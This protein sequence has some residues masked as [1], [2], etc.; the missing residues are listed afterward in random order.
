MRIFQSEQVIKLRNVIVFEPKNELA[1]NSLD[2]KQLDY[3]V[4]PMPG[5]YQKYTLKEPNIADLKTAIWNDLPQEFTDKAIP[6]FQLR[7]DFRVLLQLVGILNTTLSL[8]IE[9]ATKIR[10][11][12][13]CTGDEKVVQSLIRY[14]WI[15]RTRLHV[16][17]KKWTLHLKRLYLLN[18]MGYLF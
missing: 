12:N 16:H 18:H 5:H 9:R 2:L 11:W 7:L 14:Y 4:G 8:N 6:L 15:Y 3:H 13:I 10:H 17:L 1:P